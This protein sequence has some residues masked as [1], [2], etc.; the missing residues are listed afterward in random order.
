MITL[1][2]NW[3]FI[4]D[5][6]LFKKS[7]NYNLSNEAYTVKN[8]FYIKYIIYISQNRYCILKYHI[9]K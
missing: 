9:F 4:L 7:G 5:H 8:I 1:I 2:E 6:L 3:I